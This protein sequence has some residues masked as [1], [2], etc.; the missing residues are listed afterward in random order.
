[1]PTNNHN[2]EDVF[3]RQGGSTIAKPKGQG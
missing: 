2:K 1:M 3:G